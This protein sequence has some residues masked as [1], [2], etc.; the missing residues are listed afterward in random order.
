MSHIVAYN[1]R[2]KRQGKD[3]Y[4]DLVVGYFKRLRES[5]SVK[6]Q[7]PPSVSEMVGIIPS[8]DS[9][10]VGEYHD[11]IMERYA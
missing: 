6:N 10:P 4:T 9:D 7:L 2:H 3:F 8:S 11:H 1:V 5:L